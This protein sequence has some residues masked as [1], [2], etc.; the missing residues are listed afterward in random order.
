MQDTHDEGYEGGSAGDVG[1]NMM[2][3]RQKELQKNQNIL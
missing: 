1:E 2:K 3:S